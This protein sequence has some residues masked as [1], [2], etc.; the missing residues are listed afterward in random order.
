MHFLEHRNQ[1]ALALID[2][3]ILEFSH[4]K[5]HKGI[6]GVANNTK[7]TLELIRIAHA[8]MYYRNKQLADLGVKKVTDYTP[9][10]R[11][12]RVYVTGRDYDESDMIQCRIDGQELQISAAELVE[13]LKGD[14]N[15]KINKIG[16]A[17]V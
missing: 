13:Y 15:G 8:C 16:R 9:T 12:G 3:K 1:A 2:P 17:H 6:V 5:G 7:E 10:K 14:K 11:T 4:Y